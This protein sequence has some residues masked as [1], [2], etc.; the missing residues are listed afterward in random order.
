MVFASFTTILNPS[1]ANVI[2]AK[3]DRYL[4]DATLSS[5]S[6]LLADP[7]ERDH[8]MFGAGRRI[9]PGMIVAEREIW[10]TISRMLWAFDMVQIPEKPIDLK[11]YDGMSGRSP[12][13]FEIVLKPRFDRM[14][15]VL[16]AEMREWKGK[17]MF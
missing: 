5:N 3:P 15:E 16:E 12:V 9:C 2:N 11:E 14:G 1:S 8:W 13:L 7:Y 17:A 10:L 4:T 6:A